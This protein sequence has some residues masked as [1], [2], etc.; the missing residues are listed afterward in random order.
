MAHSEVAGQVI[1]TA[2]YSPAVSFCMHTTH[3]LCCPYMPHY[4]TETVATG[5]HVEQAAPESHHQSHHQ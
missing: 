1:D 4:L 3:C 5:L 2:V